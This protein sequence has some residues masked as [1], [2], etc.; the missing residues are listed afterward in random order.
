M[1]GQRKV[2]EVDG[3]QTLL[4]DVQIN[5]YKKQYFLSPGKVPTVVSSGQMIWRE[6]ES[7]AH[8]STWKV[9]F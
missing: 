1:I 5:C 4:V 8:A 3:K 6:R 7:L 2:E 9:W